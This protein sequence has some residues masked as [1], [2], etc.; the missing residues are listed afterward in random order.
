MKLIGISG[1]GESDWL[2]RPVTP[3]I[4]LL[5][6]GLHDVGNA[7]RMVAMFGNNLRYNTERKKWIRWDEQRWAVD[8]T[9]RV[10]TDVKKVMVAFLAQTIRRG[11]VEME[12]FALRSLNAKR[13]E[14]ALSLA[15]PELAVLSADLDRDPWLLNFQNTT[16]DLRDSSCRSH[17]REDLITKMVPH[18]FDREA[19]C[20]EWLK[21]LAFMMNG[22]QE[23]VDHLQRCFGY[24]LTGSTREKTIFFLFGPGGTGKTTLLTAFREALGEDYTSLLQI[25]TLFAGRENNTTNSDI[26]D[27]CGTRFAMTSEP[28]PGARM[29]PS[30]LKRLTQGMGKVRARRLFENLISF[31]ET[32]KL[33]CDT[34]DRPLIPNAD[35]A[36]FSRLHPIPC[37]RP[38][39]KDEVDR[40]FIAKL[41]EEAPG[42]LVWAVKGARLWY[43]EGLTRPEEVANSVTS[44]QEECDNVGQ[45]IA[46]RCEVD[47]RLSVRASRVYTAYRHWCEQRREEPLTSTSF[48]NQ[49]TQR[50]AKKHT[51]TGT[52]YQGISVK[53]SAEYEKEDN[54]RVGKDQ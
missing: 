54:E 33:W 27:L 16:V 37:L 34:N 42:I 4:D 2:P 23:L 7:E 51:D 24:S 20:Q 14:Y 29:S 6:F 1:R 25:S 43:E 45:F 49:L 21:L 9:Q 31:E 10:R 26:S 39:P 40:S 46:E 18:D 41:R 22:K 13:L 28:D 17:A 15:Q 52:K 8:S 36:T 11:D 50:F 12:K 47:E 19:K 53:D 32:H 5:Q 30:K 3:Q 48:G 38:I 35:P 44:W